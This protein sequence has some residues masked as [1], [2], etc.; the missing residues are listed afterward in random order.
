MGKYKVSSC[1][2]CPRPAHCSTLQRAPPQPKTSAS[3]ASSAGGTLT[4]S[5]A[6]TL[7]Q[8]LSTA[9][10]RSRALS[11]LQALDLVGHHPRRYRQCSRHD[12]D[13]ADASDRKLPVPSNRATRDRKLQALES[14]NRPASPIIG[15][16]VRV[17]T[18][19]W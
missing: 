19:P 4:T 18:Q 9:A 11:I 13:D 6:P 17:E 15:S 14:A 7:Y 5:F 2:R 12:D 1:W 10:T 3:L 8:Y 16:G